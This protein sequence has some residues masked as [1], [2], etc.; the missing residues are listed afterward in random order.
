[1]II[2]ITFVAAVSALTK[3]KGP[4]WL[5]FTFENP[6]VYLFNSLAIVDGRT[7]TYLQHPGITTEFFGAMVLRASSL[8]P[9]PDLIV[10]ALR[11]P[12]KQIQKLHWAL[13]IFTAVVLWLA[14]W[15]TAIALKSNITGL[16]IQA[17]VLFYQTLV[18]YGIMFGSDLMQV[19]FGIAAICCCLLLLL[20]PAITG[21]PREQGTLHGLTLLLSAGRLNPVREQP[22]FV[23][24]RSPA[25]P[26]SLL[27]S[28]RIAFLPAL[29]GLICALG[30]A[31]KLTFFPIILLSLFC[32]WKRKSVATFSASFLICLTLVLLPLISKLPSILDWMFSLATHSGLYGTGAVGLPSADKYLDSVL[33]F[34]NG[35][36]L[37]VTIPVVTAVITMAITLAPRSPFRRA[38]WWQT[39]LVLL[40]IEL[41]SFAAIAKHP[42][43]HYLIPLYLITGVNLVLLYH[44]FAP[45]SVYR[46]L[47]ALG[48][49][50]LVSL[51]ALGLKDFISTTKVIYGELRQ[52]K[53]ALLH[54]YRHAKQIAGNDLLVDYYV[55]DSPL[56]PIIY[57]NGWAGYAFS[58]QLQ[59]I[60]GNALFFNIW[61]G[62][63]QTFSGFIDS[64]TVLNKYDHI[65]F[66]GSAGMFPK[67]DGIDP[68]TFETIDQTSP[69]CFPYWSLTY[70]LYKWT[71]R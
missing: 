56:Y 23:R 50:V 8:E 20:P 12:E 37:L 49:V 5:P 54:L 51:L 67:I 19:P 44:S 65:Y 69:S 31:T 11:N 47:K 36:P 1:L 43:I 66:L 6:Y 57:G 3:A 27:S 30:I 10:S 4:Q 40:I 41:V 60:Y 14:P 17:P 61:R 52:D 48:W 28:W 15:F 70:C 46:S 55:S 71:R 62:Q 59:N 33:Y 24:D 9:E 45:S 13:L 38:G 68:Q 42:N 26:G 58:R 22:D 7:P 21:A 32:C 2:P 35:G 53:V 16:L 25:M 39:V 18:A 34:L 64:Q 63:F 29:T